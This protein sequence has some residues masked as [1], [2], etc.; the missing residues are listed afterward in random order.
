IPA[1]TFN[2]AIP[3]WVDGVLSKTV[4]PDPRR[5]YEAMSEF[6]HDLNQPNDKLLASQQTPWIERDPLSFWRSATLFLFVTNLL[7]LYFVIKH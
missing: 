6:L 2:K 7:L 3:S 1:R 5:R 4:N